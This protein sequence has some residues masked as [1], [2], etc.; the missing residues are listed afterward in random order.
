MKGFTKGKALTLLRTNPSKAT[1]EENITQFKRR[2]RDRGYSD[3]FLEN[4]LSE[5]K[6]NERKS[7][8]P[9]KQRTLLFVTEYRPSV[10]NLKNILMSK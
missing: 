4:T 7:A 5:V 8:L 3:N 6:F 10:L 1:F 2:L 9:N